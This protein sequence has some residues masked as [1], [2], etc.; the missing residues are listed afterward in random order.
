MTS[1]RVEGRIL[2]MYC[3]QFD[4]ANH[5]QA[6]LNL[7][8]NVTLEQYFAHHILIYPIDLADLRQL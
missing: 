6:V 8:D 4:L 1:T 2:Y 3:Q 5:D 7:P